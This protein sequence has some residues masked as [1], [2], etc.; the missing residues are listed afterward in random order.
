LLS[1]FGISK[2]PGDNVAIVD[3]TTSEL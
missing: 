2:G 3:A 1:D